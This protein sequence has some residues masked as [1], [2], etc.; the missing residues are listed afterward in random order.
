MPATNPD[1]ADPIA[2]RP[3]STALQLGT[4]APSGGPPTACPQRRYY[5]RRKTPR[6][7]GSSEVNCCY[8]LLL[9]TREESGKC[10]LPPP[11][12]PPRLRRSR[13]PPPV[14][15][16]ALL[17]P[18][19]PHRL[20]P[21]TAH[22]MVFPPLLASPNARCESDAPPRSRRRPQVGAPPLLDWV[23]LVAHHRLPHPS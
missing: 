11:P 20:P 5:R 12:P 2:L 4:T 3:R 14:L 21:S 23:L 18:V 17:L 13:G 6:V 7:G 10:S 1:S 19:H 15:L 22:H 16:C 8:P 9:A